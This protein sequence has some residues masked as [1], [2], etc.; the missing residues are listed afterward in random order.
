MERIREMLAGVKR[1]LRLYR[2]GYVARALAVDRHY[3]RLAT[4][5]HATPAELAVVVHLY[6][7]EA[8]PA[9][10]RRLAYINFAFDLYVSVPAQHQ[11]FTEVI[12]QSFPDATV[13]VVPNRGRDVLPFLK[14]MHIIL[15]RQHYSYVLKLHSK[16]STHRT[17][18]SVWFDTI[19]SNLLPGREILS[20]LNPVL[21]KPSTGIIGPRGEYV[22]LTVNFEANGTYMTQVLNGVYGKSESYRVLHT[23]RK[24]YGFFA[25]TMFWARVDALEPLLRQRFGARHFDEEKGQ[26]DATFA[27][28]LE[29][30]MGVIPEIEGRQFYEISPQ[31]IVPV[32]YNQGVVPDW[33]DVY[34]GP[35]A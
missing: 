25:G 22:S 5:R 31:G 28:A 9:I 16:K 1:R 10:Q 20:K 29:R 11:T 35:T 21:V 24:Q 3:A 33:S 23:N 32:A 6:Y 34:K 7:P 12:R 13:Y 27:H 15:Q 2:P 30:L 18:G 14:L 26:I 17:D 19:L 8:W 4:P